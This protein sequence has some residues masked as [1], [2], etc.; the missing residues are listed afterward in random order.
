V[1]AE[2]RIELNPFEEPRMTSRSIAIAVVAFLGG[3]TSSVFFLGQFPTVVID[4]PAAHAGDAA[5]KPNLDPAALHAE[6]ERL[7]SI[8]PDQSHAMKDVDYHF[9]N[10][11]FA[12]KFR[13]T[14]FCETGLR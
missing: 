8:A 7:K 3:V 2:C 11:W 5:P 9:T 12:G 10:L 1:D 6:I 14:D 4:L 13:F